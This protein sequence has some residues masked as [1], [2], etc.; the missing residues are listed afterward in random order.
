MTQSSLPS[1]L[2]HEWTQ[3]FTQFSV[4]ETRTKLFELL[5]STNCLVGL[6]SERRNL[7]E[8]K[9]EDSNR[10]KE[11]NLMRLRSRSSLNSSFSDKKP[12]LKSFKTGNKSKSWRRNAMPI[13]MTLK[14]RR[15]WLKSY[16]KQMLEDNSNFWLLRK[17]N[18][19]G[20]N[21]LNT[22]ASKS[23]KIPTIK[24]SIKSYNGLRRPIKDA[25]KKFRLELRAYACKTSTRQN[26][27]W[28]RPPKKNSQSSSNFRTW[29]WG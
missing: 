27:L 18:L 25:N 12:H 14:V 10:K 3:H 23:S 24:M 4:W 5:L 19:C 16:K 20:W 11:S 1:S 22:F 17:R 2:L 26:L 9:K 13:S 15:F 29:R 28:W 21:F 6:W 8:P 7:S